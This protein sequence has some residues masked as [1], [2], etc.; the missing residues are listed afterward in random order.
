MTDN[1]GEWLGIERRK[2]HRLRESVDGLLEHTR[3]V[4][5]RRGSMDNGDMEAAQQRFL[6]Y[7][8]MIWER[9]LLDEDTLESTDSLGDE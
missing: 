2:D 6:K 5:G 4:H 7:A 8:N 3:E 9:L 1:S